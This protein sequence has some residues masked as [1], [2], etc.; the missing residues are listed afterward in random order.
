MTATIT[1]PPAVRHERAHRDAGFLTSSLAVAQ[2]TV[3]KFVRTPQLLV[4]STVQGALFLL[5]FRYVFGGAIDTGG[6][7]YVDFL[8]PG[9]VTT[10][11]LFAGSGATAGVAEDVDEDVRGAAIVSARRGDGGGEPVGVRP[12]GHRSLGSEAQT[13]KDA[14]WPI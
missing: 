13:E 7:P 9:F 1:A 3:R 8:V 10:T 2:R 14:A 4:M 5:I 12:I 11:I 6:V